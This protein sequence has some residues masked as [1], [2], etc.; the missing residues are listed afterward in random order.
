M[1]LV[2][3]S[4]RRLKTCLVNLGALFLG[5]VLF[6]GAFPNVLF[7]NG[8]PL[9]AWIAYVPVFWLIRRVHAAASFLWGALYGY[10]AYTLFNFWLTAFH[11]VAGMV[12]GIV[13]LIYFALL[14]PLLKFVCLLYPRRGYILQW[15]CWIGFEYLRT[16]GFLGYAYG[17]TG[18]SQWRSAPIIQIADT[19]GV[20]GV[21]AL[22]VFPSV[23]LAAGLGESL[24]PR[25]L[26][27][28]TFASRLGA[29]FSR[30]R[31]SAVVWLAALAGTLLYGFTAQID[32]REA[33]VRRIALIQHNT[34]PWLGGITE[35]RTNFEV[36]KR[37]SDE[38][39]RKEPKPDLVVWSETAFVPRIY[40]HINYRG[41][42][43]S[44]MLVT[45]LMKYLSE[46]EVP[47]VIGNDD[48]RKEPE[49]NPRAAEEY[50][51]DYNA[52]M[53]IEKGEILQQYRKLHLVPFTEHFPY[54]KQFP[55]LY[56]ELKNR[57]DIHLWER[58]KDA[59][60]F[61]AR[62]IRFSSPICFEDTFGYLSRIFTQNGADLI[63]NLSNDAWSKSLPAQMQ[64]LAMAVFR[65]VE[66]RRS[67]VRSTASGQTCGIDPNGRI[68]AMAPPFV[69]THLTVAVPVVTLKTRYTVY[70]DFFPLV[71][72]AAGCILL[73]LGIIGAILRKPSGCKYANTAYR[74]V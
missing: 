39:L 15:L 21:S 52:V 20:W 33:P 42:P 48:A 19:F 31:T 22:V 62:G 45:D 71:C 5:A 11:P 14:F 10:T 1:S 44:Y 26:V 61:E 23:W 12:V 9:L 18:Y 72:I 25:S 57:K 36:L 59:V 40:W 41:D 7:E 16:R 65:S 47:F 46:K 34:D 35:Y 49:K 32:Y 2:A 69:E 68:L 64:H 38:A 56:E 67:M 63:I 28:D 27:R 66:N 30:E 50:R 51:V 74:R 13:Y 60:V 17:I 4:L 73:I 43:D 3:T 55:R 37:L 24:R 29:F 54:K 8:L 6:A 58:G 70:G 53:L